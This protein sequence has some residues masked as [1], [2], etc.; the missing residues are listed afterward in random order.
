[1][2]R[3]IPRGLA[4]SAVLITLA[5]IGYRFFFFGE[6]AVTAALNSI[7]GVRLQWVSGSADLIP[8]WYQARIY[9][10]GAPSAYLSTLTR[11]SFG[12]NGAFCFLQVG[13]YAVRWTAYG[14]FW[15]PGFQPQATLSNSFCFNG[16]G[17]DSEGLDLFP[18]RIRNVREF[19]QNIQVI[20]DTL[21]EWPR[22]PDY[23]DRVDTTGR[24]YR[25]CTNPDV[26][27]DIWPPQ[28]GWEK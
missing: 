12:E 8:D 14:N 28:Y 13:D 2:G 4:L 26:S 22:C 9:V 21:E 20:Q 3:S 7:P 27:T 11:Q 18:V 25:V 10:A 17:S 15:G 16:S 19:V 24:R 5:A 23:K 6:R 1:M